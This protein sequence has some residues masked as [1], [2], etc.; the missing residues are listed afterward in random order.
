MIATKAGAALGPSGRPAPPRAAVLISGAST[1][2]GYATAIRLA[3]AGFIV[4]A[5]VRR[6]GDAYPLVREAGPDI[7]PVMLDVT[8]A[9]SISCACE[10]VAARDDAKLLGLVNNA[11]TAL[12]GPLELL[13]LDQMRR[14]F[15]VN[16]FGA[17]ALVQAFAPILR[18]TRGRIVNVSA[19][20]G[21]LASP[22]VG[23]Y[24]A[25]K[26]ALEAASDALRVELRAFGV[27]VA[28]V[29]PGAV[30]SPLWERGAE[31]SLK[32]LEAVAVERREAYDEMIRRVVRSALRSA[33]RG[34][35]PE[36]VAE[37]IAHALL[38]PQPHARYVVGTDAH[39]ALV[40][41]RMPEAIRD[42]LAAATISVA[43][44]A[45]QAPASRIPRRGPVRVTT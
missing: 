18:T 6:E 4:F 34:M 41:A 36:R 45:P 37:A 32:A 16:F 30:K 5:G 31:L 2:V 9:G 22:F 10:T 39:I 42:R 17:V 25:S 20:G 24:A 3:R 28:V 1:G 44:K 26:F 12:A 33:N 15:E 23:A 7:V 27:H 21:K 14:Q 38:A 40:I 29:E 11:G 19:I 35:P 13:P 8:D 43:A